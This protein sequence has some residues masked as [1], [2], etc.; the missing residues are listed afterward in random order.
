MTRTL[1]LKFKGWHA[2]YC[3]W[4]TM[5][6]ATCLVLILYKF[7]MTNSDRSLP[8]QVFG[9]KQM[10]S[11]AFSNINIVAVNRISDFRVTDEHAPIHKY[12]WTQLS[13]SGLQGTIYICP[14]AQVP[15][16]EDV[17]DAY[18]YPSLWYSIKARWKF[19]GP[20]GKVQ[21]YALARSLEKTQNHYWHGSERKKNSWRN[22]TTLITA[23]AKTLLWFPKM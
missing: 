5:Y 1:K 14:F 19:Q 7:K 2:I 3:Y 21:C 9:S 16:C 8:F 13:I 6:Q 22:Q 15:C 10:P 12:T 18:P 20:A 11:V 23:K 17:K 4:F